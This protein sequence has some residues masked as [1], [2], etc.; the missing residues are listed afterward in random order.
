MLI[1]VGVDDA[2][3]GF[4]AVDGVP[5]FVSQFAAVFVIGVADEIFVA[6]IRLLG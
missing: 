3:T 1:V 6:T 4:D 5:V 2:V